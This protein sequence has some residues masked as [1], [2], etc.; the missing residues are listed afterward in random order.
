M[1]LSVRALH[2]G[3]LRNLPK[4][5]ILF[6]SGWDERID[7]AMIMYVIEGGDSP[8]IV[9]TGT[10]GREHVS[11]WHEGYDLDR[12]AEQEPARAL[13]DAGIDPE[14]VKT[15]IHT[16]LHWDHSS[17]ND[18]FPNARILVQEAE[19][20]YAV[21]PVE[22]NR[23]AYELNPGLRPPWWGSLDRMVPVIGEYKVVEGVTLIPLPGHTP[24]S[25]GVLVE[26][27]GTR[28]LIAGDC[29]DTYEN[30]AGDKHVHHRPS[31]AFTNLLDYT[32]SLATIE[33]LNCEV[34]P[35]HDL[36]VVKRGLFA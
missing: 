24:G 15:I 27:A 7:I 31:G 14:S 5:A 8:I 4:P 2:L 30:W 17:N 13:A 35:S 19:L 10:P 33:S 12:P 1:A 26:A 11:R 18:L 6:Q 34:I 32:K 3:T 29:L 25:Q 16:H 36:A 21:T 23:V 9:D 28:Y 22:V 20:H